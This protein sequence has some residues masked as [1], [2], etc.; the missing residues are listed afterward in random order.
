[1][2]AVT[3]EVPASERVA[4]ALGTGA[5]GLKFYVGVDASSHPCAAYGRA[6]AA[7][8]RAV[9]AGRV[10]GRGRG[11]GRIHGR[12]SGS[13]E[14]AW[15]R[16]H[17][18]PT[19]HIAGMTHPL[20][21]LFQDLGVWSSDGER[22]PHEPLLLLY[23]LGRYARGAGR[24]IEYERMEEDLRRLFREF[25]PP[26]TKDDPVHL[27]GYLRTDGVWEMPGAEV[28]EVREGEASEPTKARPREHG[29]AGGLTPE[30]HA[31]V[32]GDA[33][34][35]RDVA[36]DLLV[37]HFPDTLHAEIL[38]AVGL[39]PALGMPPVRRDPKFR[40]QVLRAYDRRCAVCA[41]DARLGDALVGL[42][43]AHIRWHQAGGPSSV[44]NGLALCVLHHKL[45]DRGAFTLTEDRRVEVSEELHGS[46]ATEQWITR[47]HGHALRVP[48]RSAHQPEPA[49][50][51]WHRSEVFRAP[52]RRME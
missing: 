32:T 39:D 18:G 8:R 52:G 28:A 41:F 31:A 50:I 12:G 10:R 29:I 25:G 14:V 37:A 4:R 35:L 22:S 20:R 42:E 9:P 43:A 47:F 38:A 7:P 2:Q 6:R 33:E 24:L 44:S 17:S 1:M 11:G 51:A 27:F 40:S 15:S 48:R 46:S 5:A 3:E 34:L 49:F 19:R 26:R 45:F 23:V 16:A 13:Y 30:M 36:G 21:A